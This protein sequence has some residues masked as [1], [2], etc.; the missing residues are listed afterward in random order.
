VCACVCRYVPS[1]SQT[2]D[3]VTFCSRMFY[4]EKCM[5]GMMGLY[6]LTPLGP[7]SV[8]LC[9]V[10]ADDAQKHVFQAMA[11]PLYVSATHTNTYTHTHTYTVTMKTALFD[12]HKH[13]LSHAHIQTH[14]QTKTH[15]HLH[16]Y[17]HIHIY[18][19]TYI[20]THTHTYTHIYA[21]THTDVH[22]HAHTW[23]GRCPSRECRGCW[24]PW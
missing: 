14:T 15:L 9:L 2:S 7:N 22:T 12:A 8:R 4:D 3:C 5:R 23:S 13:S 16:T 6:C 11:H 17:I 18:T 19:G 21:G 24:H 1:Y 20:H 10:L